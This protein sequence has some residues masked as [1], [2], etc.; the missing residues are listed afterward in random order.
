MRK[1]AKILSIA[2]LSIITCFS[3]S[4]CTF[5]NE[6][7]FNPSGTG[8]S[9]VNSIVAS[10]NVNFNTG[11]T[12][13]QNPLSLVDAYQKVYRT[14]VAIGMAMG[15]EG[16]G[17]IVDVQNSGNFVYIITCHHVISAGGEIT[18]Y[19][20]DEKGE[21]DNEDY[22]FVGEIGSEI[23]PN[24]AVTLVGGDNV[25]DIAVIKINLNIAAVSGKK[26]SMDKI[27]KAVILPE[28][29]EVKVLE[30]IFAI[31]NPLG[32]LPGSATAG[33]VS[34]L[35]R[36]VRVSEVGDMTLMQISVLTNPGNSGGGLY[37]LYGELIGITN[38][39]NTSFD[40][41]N[42]AIPSKL[43]NGNG[44]VSIARQLISTATETNYGYVSGRWDIGI[45]I[46][47]ETKNNVNYVKI[48]NVTPGSNAD[49]AGLKSGYYITG[50]SWKGE[51][52]QV[53]PSVFANYVGLMRTQLKRGDSFNMYVVNQTIFAS[54][55]CITV[56]ITVANYIFCNTGL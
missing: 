34:Y 44:F 17:V 51:N 10:E 46:D 11:E 32:E 15:G 49:L 38:A 47:Y 33:E 41:I 25:S 23:Y 35:E 21:Y 36:D 55:S 1:I 43:G 3:I 26:L 48:S 18:V 12:N 37:N 45:S 8:S 52:Y 4:G 7:Y 9:N 22:I 6:G 50:L 2:I 53:S 31:G 39:G 27:Q 20:P 56:P 40:G 16:S 24:R 30:T 14:S 42:F 29:R 13:E 54:T 5:I 28:N 19:V